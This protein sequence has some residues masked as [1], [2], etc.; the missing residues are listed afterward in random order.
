VTAPRNFVQGSKCSN[1]PAIPGESYTIGQ[2][3]I[4]SRT[5]VRKCSGE[6]IQQ[7]FILVSNRDALWTSFLITHQPHSIEAECGDAVPVRRRHTALVDDDS[8]LLDENSKPDP[9]VSFI[10]CGMP[11]QLGYGHP[12]FVAA[13]ANAP[14]LPAA[15]N[16]FSSI[17]PKISISFATRPVQ[18]VW[19]PA[20][21]PA[22]LSP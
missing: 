10:I 5:K 12:L 1:A 6:V 17:R 19:W 20:P 14:L 22:P 7:D 2:S 4:V 9:R 13:L 15:R 11:W 21:R 8:I 16:C 3:H 18:P